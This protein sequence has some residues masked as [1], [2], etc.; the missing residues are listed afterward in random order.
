[1]E[2]SL[3]RYLQ[4]GGAVV[5]DALDL[6]SPAPPPHKGL[7]ATATSPVSQGTDLLWIPKTLAMHSKESDGSPLHAA[8]DEH[9]EAAG[10]QLCGTLRL[11]L[12]LLH[13]LHSPGSRWG[14]YLLTLPA[15]DD[16]ALAAIPLLWK[17]G[18]RRKL[19]QGT[20]LEMPADGA[21]PPKRRRQDDDA[22]ER[23]CSVALPTAALS[24]VDWS[25][26]ADTLILEGVPDVAEDSPWAGALRMLRGWWL[27]GVNGEVV[28]GVQEAVAAVSAAGRAG[29]RAVITLFAPPQ[30]EAEA[31]LPAEWWGREEQCFEAEVAPALRKHPRVWPKRDYASF[32]YAMALVLSRSFAGSH[33]AGGPF[34]IPAIDR[35][36]H[37][38][39][40]A[41]INASLSWDHRGFR[42]VAS[43][44]IAKGGEVLWT[45]G[46]LSGSELLRTHGFVPGLESNVAKSAALSGASVERVARR[47]LP[48]RFA[49]RSSALRAAGLLGEPGEA[50]YEVVWDSAEPPAI[51][52]RLLCLAH[53][54]VMPE[55]EWE[56]HRGECGV[57]SPAPPEQGSKAA[58]AAAHFMSECGADAVREVGGECGGDGGAEGRLAA[59]LR[60]AERPVLQGLLERLGKPPCVTEDELDGQAR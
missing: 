30:D 38:T 45:Y 47:L 51:P 33:D 39:E 11:T 26:G 32:R 3:R 14:S 16:A 54:L 22:G 31:G 21:P 18:L 41:A 28:G 9:E 1:M 25:A 43:K 59:A 49:G 29:D 8:L 5:H 10:Q 56:Q 57:R 42:V 40:T 4:A 17:P 58:A 19:L 6:G 60:A 50:G 12:V 7:A 44:P 23:Q 35:M 46:R 37:A 20:S 2:D 15:A 36:N 52:L 24:S 27:I 48:R 34:L 53:Y 55:A 13:H